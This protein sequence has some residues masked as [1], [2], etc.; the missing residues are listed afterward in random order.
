MGPNLLLFQ[1][2]PSAPLESPWLLLVSIAMF[3]MSFFLLHQA[4]GFQQWVT[5]KDESAPNP[6]AGVSLAWAI[7][8]VMIVGSVAYWF[9]RHPPNPE[10]PN[11]FLWIITNRP[12][13]LAAGPL[14]GTMVPSMMSIFKFATAGL[15]MRGNAQELPPLA[16]SP[17]AALAAAL[18]SLISLAGSIA[19]L[20]MFFV[21]I[22]SP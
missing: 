14:L 9:V 20:V 7:S 10:E 11:L 5:G 22:R 15:I 4:V 2:T 16:R 8:L 17:A 13:E 21:W 6:R 3:A 18:V 12:S 19:T 1:A